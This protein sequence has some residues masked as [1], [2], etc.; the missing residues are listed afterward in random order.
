MQQKKHKS[1]I[2]VWGDL[3]IKI[4]LLNVNSTLISN[5]KIWKIEVQK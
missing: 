2:I 5:L 3:K 4:K 1:G